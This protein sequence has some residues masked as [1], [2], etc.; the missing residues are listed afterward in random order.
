MFALTPAPVGQPRQIVAAHLWN[1]LV[2]LVCRLIPDRGFG[3]GMSL[4]WKQ[5]LAVALGVSGQGCI[6]IMHP[7]AT[8]LSFAF[9]TMPDWRWITIALVVLIDV[10]VIVMSVVILNL[11][12]THQYPLWWFG[13]GWPATGGTTRDYVHHIA[14]RARRRGDGRL[15]RGP[16]QSLNN[17]KTPRRGS[18]FEQRQDSVE[19][20]G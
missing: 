8:G 11:S 12:E 10:V 9:V 17:P 18:L 19:A 1:I 14:Q 15:P 20:T 5:S 3:F 7:P 2:G 4:I 13:L 16:R 6:G